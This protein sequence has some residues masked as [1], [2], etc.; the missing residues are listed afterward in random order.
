M[1]RVTSASPSAVRRATYS[2]A[3]TPGS[4]SSRGAHHRRIAR[5]SGESN[6]VIH[7]G[8]G[9]S[10]SVS[11][12]SSLGRSGVARRAPCTWWSTSRT[13]AT[14]AST[15]LPLVVTQEGV[16]Q[17]DDVLVARR[18]SVEPP[19]HLG[20]T[21]AGLGEARAHLGFQPVEALVDPVE[22]GGGLHAQRVDRPPVRV[23][24][25]PDVGQVAVVRGGQVPR[26]GGVLSRGRRLRRHVLDARFQ[27]GQAALGV[28]G[29]GHEPS[30]PTR[31]PRRGRSAQPSQS[32][33]ARPN[34]SA[35]TV[36]RT[37]GA[38]TRRATTGPTR[39][40]AN[41]PTASGATSGHATGPVTA[42]T[43]PAATVDAPTSM[44]LSAFA[45]GRS[46][47]RRTSATASVR[48]PEPAP[49]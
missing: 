27:C 12:S 5:P 14:A 39:L 1:R 26:R 45:R 10:D 28:G 4:R 43:T 49:K 29:L 35:A 24:L 13:A 48:I 40:P 38:G 19:A 41:S 16:E 37:T 44:F 17:L 47:S 21:P 22:A 30:V 31:P 2:S 3:A 6:I 9:R 36:T 8:T 11:S 18:G 25:E 33:T 32:T 34:P 46:G 7:G 15:A 20:E 23:D 42:S